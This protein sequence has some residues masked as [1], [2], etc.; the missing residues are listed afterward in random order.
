MP[1]VVTPRNSITKNAINVSA[2]V[3]L[4]SVFIERRSGVNSPLGCVQPI[5]P[6]PGV[7]SIKFA[8]KINKNIVRISGKI[9]RASF[10]SSRVSVM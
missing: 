2:S 5:L 8:V 10:S 3:V 6:I 4:R 1:R 7:N 9:L